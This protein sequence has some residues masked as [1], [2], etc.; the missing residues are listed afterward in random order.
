MRISNIAPKPLILIDGIGGSG[1]TSLAVKIAEVVNA[2]LVHSD[3]VCWNADPIHWDGEMLDG[4]INPWLKK[5]I[6]TY[7]PSGW[8][9]MSRPGCIDVDPNKALIIEGMGASRKTLRAVASYS[10]WVDA[11]PEIARTR[12]VQRDLANGVDG[13][14][15]ESIT[16]FADWWDSLLIPFLLKEKSWKYVDVIISG[17]SS[18][19]ISN[20]FMIHVPGVQ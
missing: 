10:I 20:N 19:F 13:G 12:L 8:I 9:K 6:V 18:D 11:E 16:Q 15:I 5:N 17:S 1:K 14:T 4:I 2:N 3:D 7:R